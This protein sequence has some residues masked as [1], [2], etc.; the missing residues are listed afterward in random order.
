MDWHTAVAREV[1]AAGLGATLQDVPCIVA[2]YLDS[3]CEAK[4]TPH[5]AHPEAL[6]FC[7]F[8]DARRICYA[9]RQ[10][11][12]LPESVEGIGIT[13]EVF[14][15]VAR[16]CAC[17]ADQACHICSR[18]WI[19]S[20]AVEPCTGAAWV[21]HPCQSEGHHEP[22]IICDMALLRWERKRVKH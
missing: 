6:R 11:T 16:Q 13:Y 18:D 1:L 9:C 14:T 15:S 22:G 21:C 3:V 5:D 20:A 17:C 2:D 19:P 12:T 10:N 8:C 4:E 7:Q